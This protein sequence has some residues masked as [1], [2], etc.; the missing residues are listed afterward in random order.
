[1]DHSDL[2]LTD[3]GGIQEE[4]PSLGKPVLVMRE[5]TERPEAVDAG[6]VLLVGT[7]KDKI[8]NGVEKVL[9]DQNVYQ[10]MCK[11]HN[12]YGDGQACQRIIEFLRK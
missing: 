4:G 2:I 6:T 12:P 3:S 10:T 5:V 11:A 7:D 1:M 9:T 8:V